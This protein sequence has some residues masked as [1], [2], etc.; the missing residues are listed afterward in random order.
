MGAH[1]DSVATIAE[2]KE[3]VRS[4]PYDVGIIDQGLPDGLGLGLVRH[5]MDV[6]PFMG[7]IMY[8]VRDDAGLQHSLQSLGVAYLSNPASRAGLGEAV[9]DA[10]RKATKYKAEG[11]QKLLVDLIGLKPG[12]KDRS[13]HLLERGEELHV[14]TGREVQFRGDL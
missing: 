6:R 11:A 12:R 4:K 7:L 1:V 2:G 5:I 13:G 10:A 14:P 9:K 3:F 8:T